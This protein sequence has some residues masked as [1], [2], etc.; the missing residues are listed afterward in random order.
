MAVERSQNSN[1]NCSE[2]SSGI[3]DILH[4]ISECQ[5]LPRY[6]T[7]DVNPPYAP[8][9]HAVMIT[10]FYT[11]GR[12]EYFDVQLNDYAIK[13]RGAFDKTATTQSTI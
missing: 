2:V 1:F 7:N 3:N 13:N 5:S 12:I 10:G 8:I 6:F 9:G 11:D 4:E